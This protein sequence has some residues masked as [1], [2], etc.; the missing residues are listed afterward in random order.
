MDPNRIIQICGVPRFGIV[1]DIQYMPQKTQ[2][3]S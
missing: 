2:K 3:G 1:F